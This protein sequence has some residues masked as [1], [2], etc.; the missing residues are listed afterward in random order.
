M[1]MMFLRLLLLH[2]VVLLQRVVQSGCHLPARPVQT[3]NLLA[4]KAKKSALLC[5]N[6]VFW[7][8]RDLICV[9]IVVGSP[10]AF[11]DHATVPHLH[12]VQHPDQEPPCTDTAPSISSGTRSCCPHRRAP[13]CPSRT[14]PPRKQTLQRTASRPGG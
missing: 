13:P 5:W 6:L 14:S 9:L 7:Q 2:R 10:P 3:L 1:M 11:N 8:P 12:G 4:H